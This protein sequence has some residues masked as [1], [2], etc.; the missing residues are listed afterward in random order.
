MTAL[1]SIANELYYIAEDGVRA[2]VPTW[3]TTVMGCPVTYE[4]GRIDEL[5]ALERA[6]AA[7]ELAVITFS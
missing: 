2:F 7:E 1:S 5:T 4:I 6:L 3:S